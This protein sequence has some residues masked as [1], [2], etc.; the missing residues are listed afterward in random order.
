MRVTTNWQP[1]RP[2]AALGRHLG[3][4]GL[5]GTIESCT[6][7]FLS[8]SRIRVA[9]VPSQDEHAAEKAEILGRLYDAE[10]LPGTQRLRRAEPHKPAWV[11]PY[12]ACSCV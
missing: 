9:G 2:F 10:A 7:S 4:A 6:A 8:D 3:P 5:A 12:S 11:T 1:M